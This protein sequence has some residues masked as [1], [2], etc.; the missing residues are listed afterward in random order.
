MSGD[1]RVTPWV[2]RFLRE[3]LRGERRLSRSTQ[4]SYRETLALL[5]QFASRQAGVNLSRIGADVNGVQTM[6]S[7]I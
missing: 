5:L 3:Y 2:A 1:H 6:L 7:S 4:H